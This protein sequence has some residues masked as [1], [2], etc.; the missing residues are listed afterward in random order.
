M[1]FKLERK[2][3]AATH[4]VKNTDHVAEAIRR[5]SWLWVA[6]LSV[7]QQSALEISN[8]HSCRNKESPPK[9]SSFERFT[10]RRCEVNA[11]F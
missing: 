7:E 3:K 6:V 2:A 5:N 10:S 9:D 8:L 11:F 4:G 1:K